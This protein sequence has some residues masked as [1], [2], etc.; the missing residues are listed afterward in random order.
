MR[1]RHF[2]RRPKRPMAWFASNQAYIDGGTTLSL[3]VGS[4]PNFEILAM[5]QRNAAQTPELVEQIQRHTIETI[6]GEILVYGQ[7]DAG[8][9]ATPN[10]LTIYHAGMRV[11]ELLPD[12][13]PPV[14]S[15]T[16][17]NEADDDWM[18]LCHRLVPPFIPTFAT[19]TAVTA[20]TGYPVLD[21]I[22]VHI[23]SKRK[24]LDNEALVIYEVATQT[25]PREDQGTIHIHKYLRTLV[26]RP[27]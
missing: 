7:L 25:F 24:L 3:S 26:S 14:Y 22:E 9:T 4:L 20:V 1:K 11:V 5:H 12:G 19:L 18:W 21:P 13:T 27:A 15:P 17:S 6:R 10:S 16:A 8:E 23:K 2:S